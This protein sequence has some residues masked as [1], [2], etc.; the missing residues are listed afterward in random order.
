[1][2]FYQSKAQE[3][4]TVRANSYGISIGSQSKDSKLLKAAEMQLK[5]GQIERYCEILV[6]LGQVRLIIDCFLKCLKDST[7]TVRFPFSTVISRSL[8]VIRVF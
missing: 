2:Y 7:D 8:C 4:E 5:L 6:E 1:M 3:L